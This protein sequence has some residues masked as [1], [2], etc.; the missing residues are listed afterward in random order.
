MEPGFSARSRW[1]TAGVCLFLVLLVMAVFGQT[2]HHEFVNYDDDAFVTNNRHVLRGLTWENAGWS[3]TAGI[4]KDS[5]DI[6]WWRPV[7]MMSHMLDVRLF[8]LNAGAHHAVSVGIHALVAVALFLVFRSM[9]GMMWRSAFVAAVFAIHPL[10]VES[11]A[12]VAERKDI[13]SGLFFVLTL[14][15]YT[16][17]ARR[18]FGFGNYLLVLLMFALGLMSKPMVVT[19]PCVLLLLDYWPL[20]RVGSVPVKRLLAEKAPLLAMSVAVS[21]LTTMGPGGIN[22]ALMA[23]LPWHLRL[24]NGLTTYGMYLWQTVW[25]TGLACLY[26][27]PGKNLS[28]GSMALAGAVITAITAGVVCQRKRR[29]LTVGWLWYLGMLVPVIGIIQSGGQAHA[30]RY[31]YLPQIG[32][33]LAVTWLAADWAEKFRHRRAWLWGVAAMVLCLLLVTAYQ[34]TSYWRNSETLWTHALECTQNNADARY[35]FGHVLQ[36]QGRTDEAIVQYRE[37]LRLNPAYT[38]V[39]CNLGLAL[40]Q[41]G[42]TGE[43][44]ARF[45]EALQLN[46][47]STDAH[48]NLG[49]ALFQQGQTEDAIA[50][51]REALRVCPDHADAHNNLGNA[52]LFGQGRS[53]EAM[54]HFREALRINPAHADAHLNLGNGLLQKGRTEEAAVQF[55]EALRIN[56]AHADAHNSLG[57]ALTRQG[58]VD[59]GIAQFREALRINPAYAAAH[60]NFGDALFQKGR[61][62]EAIAEYR[63]T[64]EISPTNVGAHYKLGKALLQQGRIEE[65]VIQLSE[66]LRLKPGDAETHNDLG[67]VLAQE[68]KAEESLTHYRE[69]LRI[70]PDHVGALYNLGNALFKQGLAEEAITQMRKAIELQPAN[71]D[72]Q[73]DL[74]WM[75]ATAPQATL[76][77]GARAVELATQASQSSGGNNPLIL[78]TLAAA[79]AEAG[80]VPNAVQ[81]TKK[82]LQLVETQPNAALAAALLRE[83]QLYEVGQ[84][85]RE[86][87]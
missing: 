25:P 5:V 43:A 63:A 19:L 42:Q 65:A 53:E 37:A 11:V 27:H 10:H 57:S 26:P 48:C 69:A 58:R 73:N 67:Y 75:L 68:G 17:Y 39:F 36:Q 29:Y 87:P 61:M 3:L 15:A 35:N 7:S 50:Q 28:L 46:P 71:G 52:L 6:D 60:N 47:A 20:G 44:I 2:F 79:Y 85:F 84:P 45:R 24:G 83:L 31:M 8:G 66:V 49:L 81:T 70:H 40:Y 16:R 80:D 1:M 51:Y 55:R 34:Q 14:G 23:S 74:A 64:L 72:I 18:P 41:L 59:E 12:W 22:N 78:E 56:P 4:G 32:L 76:R 30:D 86:N 77:N 21:V 54:A 33:Y 62:E 13:L 82:A 9:T 38:D